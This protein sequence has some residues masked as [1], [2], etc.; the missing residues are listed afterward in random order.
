MDGP[1]SRK[2]AAELTESRSLAFVAAY[3]TIR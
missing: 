1:G 2:H 3:K